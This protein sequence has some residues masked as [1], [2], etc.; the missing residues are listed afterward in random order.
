MLMFVGPRLHQRQA[1]KKAAA[2]CELLES[3]FLGALTTSKRRPQTPE[4]V[5]QGEC[6]DGTEALGRRP[7]YES[8]DLYLEISGP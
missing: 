4:T 1:E 8:G 7:V 2:S 5:D 6:F 3:T